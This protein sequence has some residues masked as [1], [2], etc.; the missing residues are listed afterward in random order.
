MNETERQK[1]GATSKYLAA[2]ILF[3][4]LINVTLGALLAR[5]ANS[6]MIT[7]IDSRMLD[8]SNTAAAM[9]DGD[10]LKAVTPEDKGTPGYESIMRTL[11]Y[12]QDN[13]DLKYIYCIR[14]MGNKNFVFG[15]DP[16]VE[17]PGEFG[18]PVIYT[19]A[20]YRASKGTPA[21]DRVAYEDAWGSFYSSYSPVFDSSG[22]VAGIVA[23]DFS[24]EWY[25]A[26][27][28]TLIRTTVIV[29]AL[30]LLV[31]GVIVMLFTSRNRKRIRTVHIQL[32]ELADNLEELMREI[33]RKT[34]FREPHDD[35]SK[36]A[37]QY[38]LED[39]DSLGN[40]ILAMQEELHAQ[41]VKVH[42]QA[43]IDALT[44][45]RNK[46]SYLNV[47]K[48]I[49]AMIAE[50]IAVFSV[51]VFDMN[52]LKAIN[53][54]YGHEF[55]DMALVDAAN[56]LI[57]IFGKRD[58]YR[59]GG[60][61]FIAVIKTLSEADIQYD[62]VRL[63]EILVAE[64]RKEKPYKTSLSLS[65]GYAVYKQGEDSEYQGVFRRADQMMYD[66]KRAYYTKYGDRRRRRPE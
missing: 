25:D 41:I 48:Q 13:I 15:L 4:I 59:I 38:G 58:L 54:K 14:D 23:V 20:L 11:T 1:G 21:V 16:T 64:N 55:G 49:D 42:E 3:A 51:I 17:D 61:E 62:F 28:A 18:S 39:V 60:D 65:K 36:D 66:D 31:G 2:L 43:Y 10:V 63:E 6:A 12:F 56:V 34:A 57:S 19:D 27:I 30:S 9:L 26:Q 47:V 44:G 40:R 53:D 46:A 22:E 32:N 5:Q 29:S 35:E 33:G 37:P 45:V 7:L 8:I 52:G 50:D 24:K